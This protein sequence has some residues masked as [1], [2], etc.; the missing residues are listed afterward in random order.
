VNGCPGGSHQWTRDTD[1]WSCVECAQT[2]PGC[3]VCGK[4]TGTTL[5]ICQPCI[6]REHN[7]LDAIIEHTTR[8]TDPTVTYTPIKAYAYDLTQ[9]RT[10]DP[11]R[12]PYGLDALY[13][14]DTL[15][16]RGIN[17][18]AGIHR[19]MSGWAEAWAAAIGDPTPGDTTHYLKAHII[20]AVNNPHIS[21]FL[22]YHREMRQ[23]RGRAYVLDP[24]TPQPV[25]GIC[26][27]CGGSLIREWAQ[28]GLDDTA[29]CTGCDRR[30]TTVEVRRAMQ[31][32]I[33]ETP[34]RNPDAAVTAT[35]AE[36]VFPGLPAAT[37]RSWAARGRI[38]SRG[39]DRRGDPL[40][41]VRD[42]E[43]QLNG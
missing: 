11:A 35:Q 6:G 39:T 4:P 5:T 12:L 21:G 23:L 25:H 40:Y 8:I 13:D 9:A 10:I 2:S 32:L 38:S 37:V 3:V 18:P 28:D 36:A 14:D 41:R 19:T 15:R 34:Q 43:E 16:V 17:T 22:T 27:T 30:Y 33:R 24:T 42:I 26:L 7:T 29:V 1:Q 20:W 31:Q